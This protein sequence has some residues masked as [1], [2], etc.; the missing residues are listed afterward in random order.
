[1]RLSRLRFNLLA[2]TIAGLSIAN[3]GFAAVGFTNATADV[4]ISGE[5]T[6]SIP[7]AAPRGPNSLTPEI[8]LAYGHRQQESIAGVGWGITGLSSIVRCAKSV[9]QNGVT[10]AVNL[11]VDDRYCLDGNQLRHVSGSYGASG[12]TYRTEIDMVARITANGTA[13][14]G[15]SWFKVEARNGLIYEYGNSTDSRIESLAPSDTTTARTWAL[16]KI[17][18]RSGNEIRFSYEEDGAPFGNYRIDKIEYRINPSAG[19]STPG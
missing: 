16:S 3:H 5:A 4:S 6:Y 1:M 8:A 13:G 11:Q 17:S 15:P 14:D 12:S 10:D 7:I 9:A 18:D 2:F 19:L